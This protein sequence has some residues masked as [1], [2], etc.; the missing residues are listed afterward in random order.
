MAIRTV[1]FDADDTLWHNESVFAMTQARFA[2]I[3]RAHAPD[4]DIGPALE[5]RE[6]ANLRL[7][8]YGIKGF[9][10]SMIETA[11]EVTDGRVTAGDIQTILDA[12]KA[13]L[14][15]PVQPLDGVSGTLDDLAGRYRLM[16]VT[17]GDLFDQESKIARSGLADRF[18]GIE[19]VS[20]KDVATYRR[21]FETHNCRPA[22]TVMVGNSVKSDVLPAIAAGA[23]AF[24]V[25]YEITW[26]LERVDEPLPD[27][28]TAL[29]SIRAVPA[30]VAALDG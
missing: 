11:I 3:V 28:A 1:I 30:A 26:A 16:I 9:T 14:D 27:R 17:K 13:M 24:H 21:V 22:E 6:R 23:F 7:F 20:E 15:H 25:P 5:A 18:D 29:E 4:A 10:L 2:E 19:I 8:G 12:G